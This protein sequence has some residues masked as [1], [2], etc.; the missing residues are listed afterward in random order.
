MISAELGNSFCNNIF[1]LNTSVPKAAEGNND[2]YNNQC[3]CECPC[4]AESNW[5]TVEFI[6]NTRITVS[7][8]CA[9]ATT[10]SARRLT[11][12][13]GEI[14]LCMF[15]ILMSITTEIA[16]WST[17][18]IRISWNSSCIWVTSNCESTSYTCSWCKPLICIINSRGNYLLSGCLSITNCAIRIKHAP[19]S[20]VLCWDCLTLSVVAKLGRT[21]SI[22]FAVASWGEVS[23]WL[24]NWT[25]W[26][27]SSSSLHSWASAI[28]RCAIVICSAWSSN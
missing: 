25:H 17:V 26:L 20:K 8:F 22:L 12:V 4:R 19:S 18:P 14:T 13:L 2:Y 9:E 1:F 24:V 15:S 5:F 11:F 7:I 10:Y 27:A 21:I 16:M 23:R 28:M 3:N 6:A